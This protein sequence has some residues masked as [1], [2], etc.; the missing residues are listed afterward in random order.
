M[1]RTQSTITTDHRYHHQQQKQYHHPNGDHHNDVDDDDD[2]YD[3]SKRFNSLEP[4]QRR[5]RQQREPK[6]CIDGQQATSSPS[7]TINVKLIGPNI[8]YYNHIEKTIMERLRDIQREHHQRSLQQLLLNKQQQ[9]SM[10]NGDKKVDNVYDTVADVMANNNTNNQSD[11]TADSGYYN[12][13]VDLP[14][15]SNHS[16]LDMQRQDIEQWL[17]S[18]EQRLANINVTNHHQQQQHQNGNNKS[19]TSE[20]KDLKSQLAILSVRQSIVI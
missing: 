14:E 5:R 11:I 16:N 8:D 18:M 2:S 7:S 13:P 9:Q 12:R 10:D 6:T 15:I 1:N 17:D 20:S 19:L 4:H 3:S